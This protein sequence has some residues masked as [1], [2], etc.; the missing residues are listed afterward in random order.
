MKPTLLVVDGDAELCD[1]YQRYFHW[2]GYEVETARDGLACLQKLRQVKPMALV[3]DR[4]LR[5]GGADGVLAWLREDRA[6]SEFPVLLTATADPLADV[7]EDVQ[8]P[9]VTLLLKPF[10]LS[11]LLEAVRN[12]VANKGP[13]GAFNPNRAESCYD[14]FTG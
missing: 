5:W 12:A 7:K 13:E 4:D 11:A 14:L 2:Y 8:P 6:L 10:A 9:V 3:L 1:L